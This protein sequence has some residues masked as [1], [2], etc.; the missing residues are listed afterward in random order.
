MSFSIIFKNGK[1]KVEEALE[2]MNWDIAKF[3]KE[4]KIFAKTQ[5]PEIQEKLRKQYN[6]YMAAL[7]W[8]YEL[9]LVPDEKTDSDK[10]DE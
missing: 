5:P 4:L 3:E 9:V 8:P 7:G 1:F 6:K 2:S 10:E